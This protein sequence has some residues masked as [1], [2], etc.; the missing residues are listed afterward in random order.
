MNIISAGCIEELVLIPLTNSTVFENSLFSFSENNFMPFW[1]SKF[2]Y[3]TRKKPPLNAIMSQLNPVRPIDPY[4]TKVQLNIILP[5]TP[6][7]SQ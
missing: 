4:P 5:S 3:V 7:S 1:N 2:H 6:R